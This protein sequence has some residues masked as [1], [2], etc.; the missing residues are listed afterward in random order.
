MTNVLITADWHLS[1][2]LR[3]SYR[4]EFINTL[5][6]QIVKHKVRLLLVLGDLTEEKDRHAARLVNNI[7]NCLSRLATTCPI[8][9][10]KGNHDYVAD[11]TTPY[12]RFLSKLPDILWINEPTPS[13]K[14]PGSIQ[15]ILGEPALFLPHTRDYQQDWKIFDFNKYQLFFCHQTFAGADSG[16]GMF[17]DGILSTVF[18][19]TALVFSGDIH[20]PQRIDQIRYCGAP[21]TVN[22][23]DNYKPRM[24]LLT[25]KEVVS[26]P[27]AGIQKR[28]VEIK[29]LDELKHQPEL[30]PGDILKIRMS[31]TPEQ[32]SDWPNMQKTI[33]AWGEKQG[34]VVHAVQ[35]TI[36]VAGL[37]AKSIDCRKPKSDEELLT[38]YANKHN[39]DDRTLRTG[40]E[41]L[42]AK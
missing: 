38:Q 28:L 5:P 11:P 31:L 19:S 1:D 2:N 8:I 13:E 27:C 16:N 10:L 12:F 40:L 23:G 39:I 3:D 20:K 17:L 42:R 15:E 41:L 25:D 37:I 33:Y 34:F 4:Q 29:S 9:V 30:N 35:P 21:Y 32:R 18:P 26:I 36:N 7:V 22:F 24:L 6:L 14:L